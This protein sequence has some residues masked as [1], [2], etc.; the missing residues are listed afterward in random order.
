MTFFKYK[1]IKIQLWKIF[2]TVFFYLNEDIREK[3]PCRLSV[4]VE[5]HYLL[6]A[7]SLLKCFNANKKSLTAR[8]NFKL[9]KKNR[10]DNW[11]IK[12][13]HY[14]IVD[15]WSAHTDSNLKEC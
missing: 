7:L 1:S 8:N 9:Y 15:S 4:R 14:S 10:S 6:Q 2:L 5:N 3:L 12:I 11:S 13:I